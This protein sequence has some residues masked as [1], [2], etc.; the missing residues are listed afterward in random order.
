MKARDK[1]GHKITPQSLLNDG[2]EYCIDQLDGTYQGQLSW[3]YQKHGAGIFQSLNYDT[4]I[5]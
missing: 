2:A 1:S 5:G 4:Y 3:S